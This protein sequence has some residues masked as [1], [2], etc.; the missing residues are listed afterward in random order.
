MLSV[1]KLTLSA[2]P[3]EEKHPAREL[4]SHSQQVLNKAIY[5]LSDLTKSLHTDRITDVGLAESIRFELLT[6]KNMGLVDVQFVMTGTESPLPEQK[7]IFL[8]R[9]FQEMMNNILKHAKATVV[10]VTLNYHDDNTFVMTLEDNGIGF[11]ADAKKN[12]SS[13]AKGVGL[14][15]M[16]N[17]AKLIGAEIKIESKAG[18]GTRIEVELKPT[19][20]I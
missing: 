3:L 12:S 2:L 1:V 5:D 6:L 13:P 14:K 11:D 4:V 9:M 7:A 18:K 10:D 15:S 16:F 8:F 17:R 19:G 20:V